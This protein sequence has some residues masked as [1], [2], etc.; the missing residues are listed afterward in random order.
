VRWRVGGIGRADVTVML[1]KQG[2]TRDSSGHGDPYRG[3]LD[4]HRVRLH[5]ARTRR[6][7]AAVHASHRT[8]WY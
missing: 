3:R 2:A 7:L 5:Q 8:P 6:G 1:A 4:V